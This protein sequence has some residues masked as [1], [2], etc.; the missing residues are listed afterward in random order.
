MRLYCVGW[1]KRSNV[2]VDTPSASCLP[3]PYSVDPSFCRLRSE[4]QEELTSIFHSGLSALLNDSDLRAHRGAH[5]RRV[6]RQSERAVAGPPPTHVHVLPFVS[7]PTPRFADETRTHV[8]R[9]TLSLA[10][11]TQAGGGRRAP[12]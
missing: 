11:G 4:T 10:R 1:A 5:H 9:V 6:T 3:I 2:H 12:G 7:A 8:E